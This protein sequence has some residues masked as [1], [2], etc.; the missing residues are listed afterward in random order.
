MPDPEPVTIIE[1]APAPEPEPAP[2]ASPEPTLLAPPVLTEAP[3]ATA[4][5]AK[6]SAL[7]W[8]IAGAAVLVVAAAAIFA[9]VLAGKGP[10]DVKVGDC[11]NSAA[12]SNNEL[13][14]LSG[15]PTVP[16]T[17]PK[18]THKVVGIV[19]N[20]PGSALSEDVCRGYPESVG[21]VWLGEQG[22]PGKIYCL[23]K[24]V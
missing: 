21:Q 9:I 15:D 14:E 12:F 8:I 20:Q 16:C 7:T 5:P 1:P 22:K 19:D 6:R 23:A 13:A 2:A 4:A 24:K 11:M 3:P 10:A 17:D 18:A